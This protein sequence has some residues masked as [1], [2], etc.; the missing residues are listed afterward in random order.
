MRT[1]VD[2]IELRRSRAGREYG[3]EGVGQV[4]ERVRVYKAGAR[5]AVGER[6]VCCRSVATFRSFILVLIFVSICSK[7]VELAT[8][9]VR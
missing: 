4:G 9:P 3:F 6:C 2:P 1:I 5:E 7:L 8:R